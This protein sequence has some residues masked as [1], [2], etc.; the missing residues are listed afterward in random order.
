MRAMTVVLVTAGI[1]LGA[2]TTTKSAPP[3]KA[4]AMLESRSGSSVSGHVDLVESAGQLRAH[5]EL[6]GLAPGSEHGF[7][8]HEKGDCSAPDASSAGGHFNPTSTAHG[9][10]GVPPHHAGDLPS[11]IADANGKVR[12]DLLL[13]GVTLAAGP[14]SIVGRAFVVHRDRDDYTSQPAGNAGP[15]LACGVITAR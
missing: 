2:C 12:A 3:L 1:A 5:V 11:L 15:R 8:V 7:H 13:E 4:G 10:S 6:A 9:R 14:T